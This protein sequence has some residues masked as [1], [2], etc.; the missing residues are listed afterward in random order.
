MRYAWH[1]RTA[2]FREGA[3]L[4]ARL[5]NWL[6]GALRSWDRR[7]AERVTHFLAISK[8]VQ[9]RIAECYGRES[10]V[11]YP[12]VDTDFYCPATVRRDDYYLIVSAFAPYK[13][14]DLAVAACN[15]LGRHLVV[16]GR[17]QEGARLRALAG[18]TIHFLGWQPDE[19]VRAH[20]R[21]CRALLFPGEE[22]FGIVP[23]EA[24]ACGAPVI[25][26]ARGGASETLIPPGGAREPTSL[27]FAEQT[28][29]CL[30]EAVMRFEKRR[31]D[32]APAAA[33]RQAQRFNARRFAEE[34]MAYLGNVLAP[35]RREERPLAA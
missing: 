6:L 27:W 3:G 11:I 13:R 22:D 12:P 31:D 20:F 18:P 32:F 33:R 34:L 15:R 25:A 5:R 2:Y 19:V 1:M 21:T 16:I 28:E 23:L 29:E 7:T 10:T 26:F 35:V 17:G 9:K 4:K 8:T 14:L 24:Q 30:M